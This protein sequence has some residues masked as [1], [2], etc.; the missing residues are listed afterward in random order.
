MFYVS[1]N[2]LARGQG[3]SLATDSL[4]MWFVPNHPRTRRPRPR[5]YPPLKK[6]LFVKISSPI[7]PPQKSLQSARDA[8]GIRNHCATHRKCQIL[9]LAYHFLRIKI[10]LNTAFPFIKHDLEPPFHTPPECPV[11]LS[12]PIPII[13]NWSGLYLSINVI[14]TPITPS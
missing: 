9:R 2:A 13:S 12:S 3:V 7:I 11:P 4:V 10:R 1:V 6:M 5:C 8:Q 14:G